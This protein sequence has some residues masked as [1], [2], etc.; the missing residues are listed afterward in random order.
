MTKRS[1]KTLMIWALSVLSLVVTAIAYSFLP[2]EIP[3]WWNFHGTVLRYAEKNNIWL[4]A[5]LAAVFAV[6]FTVLPLIDPRNKNYQRFM[7]YYETFTLVMVVAGD[8]LTGVVI[9]ESFRPGKIEVGQLVVLIAGLIC[10]VMGNLMPKIKSNYFIG[11]RNPWTLSDPDIWNRTH[12]IGGRIFF[13]FGLCVTVWALMPVWPLLIYLVSGVALVAITVVPYL[14]SYWCF[15]QNQKKGKLADQQEEE[16]WSPVMK[17]LLE[18]R[19]VRAYTDQM[20]SHELLEQIVLAG[21]FAP[22]GKNLQEWHFVVVENPEVLHRLEELLGEELGRPGYHFYGAPVIIL[23]ANK[24][25]ARNAMA[26]CSAA[27]QNMMLAAHDLGLGTCWIN[28][29]RDVWGNAKVEAYLAQLGLPEGYEVQCSTIVGYPAQS[30]AAPAR[31][32][33]TV[34]YVK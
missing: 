5:S 13:I 14:Y 15:R 27:L 11:I 9:S 17:N 10:M 33:G 20:P 28:Q 23:C 6:L 25:G 18:R 32:P 16:S 34:T 22:S 4:I 24:K 29:F 2:E 8:I 19:S 7:E 31:K 26:D 1:R 30:P 21:Q 3:M 12:R